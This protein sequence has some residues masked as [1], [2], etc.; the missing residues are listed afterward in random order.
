MRIVEQKVSAGNR[1]IF[2]LD[3][4]LS[5]PL[6]AHLAHSAERGPRDSPVWFHWQDGFIWIIGGTSFPE[7]LKRE[8]RCA[9]GIVDWN[10]ATG[11]C[12]HVGLRG[13]AEVLPFDAEK[14]RMIFRRYFGP[15]EHEWDGRFAD[16]LTGEL[17]LEIVRFIPETVIVRDQSYAPTQWARQWRRS[18]AQVTIRTSNDA[19]E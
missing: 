11:L 9:I 7:N 19:R 3:E 8:P 14:A 1:D 15:D 12:Q 4:F 10:L 18:Q 17:G 5:R 13:R 6:Y 2:D 16:V